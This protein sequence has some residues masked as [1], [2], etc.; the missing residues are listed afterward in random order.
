MGWTGG[1]QPRRSLWGRPQ[2]PLIL[3]NAASLRRRC[4]ATSVPLQ[5]FIGVMWVRFTRC[6]CVSRGA[7]IALRMRYK[8][9]FWPLGGALRTFQTRSRLRTWL[10]RIAVNVVLQAARPQ[11][12][13]LELN[14]GAVGP[15]PELSTPD[16]SPPID[17]EAAI[18][19][20]P[21]G[22]RRVLVLVSLYGYTHEEAATVLGIA[23]GTSKTQLHRARALLSVRLGLEMP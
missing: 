1:W 16:S 18:A 10:H 7:A 4:A 19:L 2:I 23:V 17:V 9:L 20:L 11:A 12:A 3:R 5:P 13:R 8:R 21:D 15:L 14:E 6:A 22:A